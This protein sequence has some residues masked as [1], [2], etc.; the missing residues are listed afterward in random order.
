MCLF[1][2]D[3]F[4]QFYLALF[5]LLNLGIRDWFIL[6]ALFN[7]FIIVFHKGFA[8]LITLIT[9]FLSFCFCLLDFST[10]H[11]ILVIFWIGLFLLKRNWFIMPWTLH[12]CIN[13]LCPWCIYTSFYNFVK[14][15]S[16]CNSVFC[17]KRMG[18]FHNKRM[19][20]IVSLLLLESGRYCKSLKYF[21]LYFY[22]LECQTF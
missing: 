21:F 9:N 11:M 15:P 2:N 19:H 7:H 8:V 13:S 6:F 12:S 16:H 20:C 17:S 18:Y 5:H 14:S 4:L 22:K 1:F 10:I 3:L